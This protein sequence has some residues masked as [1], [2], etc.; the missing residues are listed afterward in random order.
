MHQHHRRSSRQQGFT[1][2]EALVALVVTAFGMLALAGFQLS[3]STASENA[4]QRAEA[5]RLA[6]QKIDELRSFEVV[7]T[8]LMKLDFQSDIVAGGPE[9][10]NRSSADAYNTANEYRRQWWV[11][12][13]DGTAADPLELQKY[14]RVQVSW[15]DRNN[16]TQ[17]VTLR[18]VIGQSEPA[19][20]GTLAVGPGTQTARTPRNRSV[21]I[22]Y[23]AKALAGNKSAFR[24]AGA[25]VDYVFDNTTGDVLGYC[26]QSLSAGAT[27]SF[28]G[29]VTSGC[30]AR[31]AYLLSGYIRFLGGLPSGNEN[32][33]DDGI[34]NPTDTTRDLTASI[35][36]T[37]PMPTGHPPASC[38][39]ERQK[40]VTTNN[41]SSTDL[42]S[43]GRL[44]NTVTVNTSANHG[45]SVGQQ[46]AVTGTTNKSFIGQFTVAAVLGNRSFTYA[47]NAPDATLT[48]SVGTASLV[49]QLT[50][51]ESAANPNGYNTV[52]SRF[53][54]YSCVIEPYDHDGDEGTVDPPTR[55][56][57]WGQFVITPA[58]GWSLGSSGGSN[59]RLCR[60]TGDYIPD[61]KISNNEHPLYYRGVSGALDAQNYVVIPANS[62]CP[63][64]AEVDPLNSDYINTHTVLHQTAAGTTASA[65]APSS[66]SSQWSTTPEPSSAPSTVADVLPMF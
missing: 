33:V 60:F 9:T 65:G 19:V 42:V 7:A 59:S 24:P 21:D 43:I 6:Q 20:L 45:L 64:D 8:D 18:S 54:A 2:V 12:K 17:S 56:L 23:P 50:L 52:A 30:T 22:P 51:P 49:Q 11:T 14:L 31:K 57:W 38:F 37:S 3:L 58:T 28:E 55:R 66:T 4:K 10:F 15:T 13:A 39:A 26:S 48:T 27:V 25:S 5:V 47:Q 41:A 46:V 36:F 63:T 34:S 29:T 35:L 44:A 61:N 1:L 40:I 53:V 16:Q 32:Q 62:T